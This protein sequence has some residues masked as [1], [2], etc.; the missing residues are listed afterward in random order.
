M[1]P[2]PTGARHWE[3][4]FYEGRQRTTAFVAEVLLSMLLTLVGGRNISLME[5]Y[6]R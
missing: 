3:I 6:F 2:D 1:L 5:F 4:L